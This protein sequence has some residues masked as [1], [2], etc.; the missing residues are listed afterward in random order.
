MWNSNELT[1]DE[2]ICHWGDAGIEQFD[3]NTYDA[4]HPMLNGYFARLTTGITYCNDYL[5]NINEDAT[6]TAEIRFVR[7]LEYYL[8]MDAFGNVPFALISVTDLL[9]HLSC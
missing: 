2:A 9:C 8:L 7:A 3:Y 4:S 5:K 1:T 6:K